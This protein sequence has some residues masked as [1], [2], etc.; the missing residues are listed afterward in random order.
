MRLYP[1]VSLFVVVLAVSVSA[2]GGGTTPPPDV[3]GGLVADLGGGGPDARVLCTSDIDC[4]DGLFCNGREMCAPASLAAD[5]RGCVPGDA[6]CS[7]SE[8]C[9][10]TSNDCRTTCEDVDGDGHE[11]IACG[12]D[13]CDDNDAS[14]YPGNTEVCDA[15]D[16]DC[17]DA[18]FGFV[19]ADGDGAGSSACCNGTTCGDDCK[20]AGAI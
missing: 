8:T 5:V 3:D 11:A 4:N 20:A 6:P 16:E 1:S 14:R 2:C 13:D 7:L 12:G 15:H 18:T 17:N 10:E 9:D 19:D